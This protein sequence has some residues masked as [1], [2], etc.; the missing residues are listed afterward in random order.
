MHH[1]HRE[2][3]VEACRETFPADDQA[4][5]LALEPRKRPLGLEAWDVLVHGAPTWLSGVPDS[6][7]E[8]GADTPWA[9]ALAH[10]FGVIALIRRQH[11]EPLARSAACARAHVES[12]QPGRTW[13]RSS[14]L[15]G[16]GRVDHGRPEAS[17]RRWMRR[18]LPFRPEAPPSP[19]PVPGGKGALHRAVWPVHHP[20]CLGEPKEAR[21]PG[22]QRAIGVPARPPARRGT[23]GGP[24]RAPG[25]ITPA[26]AGDQDVE[27]RMHHLAKRGVRHAT[28]PRGRL[29]RKQSGNELPR[30]VAS[31]CEG[32]GHG[33]LLAKFRA[34]EHGNS[35]INY[36]NQNA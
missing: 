30:Q 14:P 2:Q 16:V 22:G 25:Q 20:A 36:L 3:G 9:E 35:V 32:A 5:V 21:V 8:L 23:V 28:P 29:W 26:A 18:P 31:S 24:W 6:C 33:A 1:R 17:V 10:V 13:A 15:A 7:R 11:L 4:A 19:P 34:L 27:S 12:I